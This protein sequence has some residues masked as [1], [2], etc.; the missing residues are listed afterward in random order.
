MIGRGRKSICPQA[1]DDIG[2]HSHGHPPP[3]PIPSPVDQSRQ[4]HQANQQGHHAVIL[5]HCQAVNAVGDHQRQ[6]GTGRTDQD[7]QNRDPDQSTLMG[8]DIK[9]NA[10]QQLS[11][12][13]FS[14]VGFNIQITKK[15]H[16]G[17][18]D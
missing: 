18:L 12:A 7:Q 9:S 15:S 16:S 11:V 17:H 14:I 10:F 8:L 3:E 4:H 2:Y 5:I 6:G 13:V 1:H